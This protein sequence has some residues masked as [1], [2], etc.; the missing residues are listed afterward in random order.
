M[1][2]PDFQTLMR[3]LLA[4][5]VD[6]QSHRVRDLTERMSDR[7]ELTEDERAQLLPSGR[8]RLIVN[9]VAWAVTHMAQ[10]GLVDRPQRG[11]LVLTQA[12]A[13][14]LQAH[15]DR[16]DMTVLTKFGAYR[17]FRNRTS[18]GP[19]GPASGDALGAAPKVAVDHVPDTTAAASPQDLVAQA[20][21]ENRAALEGE[22]LSRALALAP[23]DF[24]RLVLELLRAM[25]YGR[26]GKLEHSG[27][28]GDG[29]IDGII[30]QDPLG[31]DRIYLQ[32]KRYGADHSVGR[33]E[34]QGFVGA[35]ASNQGD[36]GVFIT[37][38]SFT[39][40]ARE[41]ADKVS[42][43]IE[44]VDGARLAALMLRH[45]VGVQVETTVTLH[46]LDEDFF[47]AL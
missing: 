43:R 26:A 20:S 28:P 33:P 16:V 30:S 15:P 3:P 47:E 19:S 39:K 37:T 34:L 23:T 4:E 44:L 46:R 12:G 36:R 40:G 32:A 18:A 10:A 11:F 7:F 31:L 13:D 9:R 41:T 25:G 17:D 5:L 6:G 21:A 38:S 22:L 1:T 8:A 42:H 24:E 27:A 29:G 2:V 45:G 14:V 35:L